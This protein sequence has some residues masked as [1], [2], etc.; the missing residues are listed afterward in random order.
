MKFCLFPLLFL[1][2]WLGATEATL[3]PERDAAVRL[4]IYLDENLF[5]PGFIDGKPGTFTQRAVASYNRAKGREE[6]DQLVQME[7]DE[8][9]DST[10]VTAIVPPSAKRFVNGSLSYK[11]EEQARA[12]ALSYRSYFEYM[13]ERYHTSESVLYE[14]N[15]KKKTWGVS[16]GRSLIVPNVEPFRIEE[17]QAGR[18]HTGEDSDLAQRKVIIDIAERQVQF[19]EAPQQLLVSNNEGAAEEEVPWRLIASF[20]TTP[21][22]DRYI[23]RGTWRLKNTIEWP[24]WRY[25][26]QM[27]EKGK[28]SD[29]ALNIPG[30]P[31][32]P[33]GVLWAGLSKS[34][35]G[36]HGTD[37]PRTIGRARSS[38]CY[39]LANWDAIRI[40]QLVRPGATVIVR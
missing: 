6:D 40:P 30:G 33:V 5:G 9:V 12:K 23:H 18:M 19:Y 27:L 10:Y 38:G 16:P 8:H 28:R 14:L 26:K 17:I 11:R 15:G 32:N 2:Q 13:A 7:A 36:I 35:I 20:P 22:Q 29:E 4:Q 39:R 24:V 37:S 21:G 31:N 34:G 25:D 1:V 3:G